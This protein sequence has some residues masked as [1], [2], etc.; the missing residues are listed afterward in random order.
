VAARGGKWKPDLLLIHSSLTPWMLEMALALPDALFYLVRVP[1]RITRYC[2]CMLCFVLYPSLRGLNYLPSGCRLCLQLHAELCTFKYCNVLPLTTL[3]EYI[4]PVAQV[5]WWLRLLPEPNLISPGQLDIVEGRKSLVDWHFAEMV[6]VTALVCANVSA[7][8]S[9]DRGGMYVLENGRANAVLRSVISTH[10]TCVV[11]CLLELVWYLFG[12]VLLPDSTVRAFLLAVSHSYVHVMMSHHRISHRRP[13]DTTTTP[14]CWPWCSS[15]C[16]T[17]RPR[18]FPTWR[19]S[20]P[21]PKPVRQ[22]L[23]FWVVHALATLCR[24][25]DCV[26]VSSFSALYVLGA[27]YQL[28][29]RCL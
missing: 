4:L 28:L 11:H 3:S 1:A 12:H 29:V 7:C 9:G 19:T 13:S 20:P 25:G 5:F 10:R 15:S 8:V 2:V 26:V 6:Q 21:P 18:C 16:G 17:L 14:R 23:R 22:V 27:S 24:C